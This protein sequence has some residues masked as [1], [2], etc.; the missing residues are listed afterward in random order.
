MALPI[1]TILVL[2]ICR[3]EKELKRARQEQALAELELRFF[4]GRLDHD[5]IGN[6][7]R[8]I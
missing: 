2:V 7:L 1:I 8:K 5:V 3:A 4:C 6:A